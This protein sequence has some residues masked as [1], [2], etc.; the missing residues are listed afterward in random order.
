MINQ[1][2]AEWDVVVADTTGAITVTLW[3][4]QIEQVFVNSSFYFQELG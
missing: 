2:L 3:E 4:S 1:Q